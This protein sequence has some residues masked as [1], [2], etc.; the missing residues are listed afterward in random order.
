MNPLADATY[1]TLHWIAKRNLYAKLL[2]YPALLQDSQASA[3]FSAAQNGNIGKFH[4]IEIGI[5]NLYDPE[6][7]ADP[8]QKL[9]ELQ[10]LNAS[11]STE[12]DYQVHEKNIN[13][14]YL[15]A[16][17]QND[18]D[19][20]EPEKATI[21]GVAALCPQAA[22]N[23]VCTAR[24]LQENYRVP[25]WN[26]DCAFVGARDAGTMLNSTKFEIYPNPAEGIVN[27]AF[28]QPTAAG[29]RVELLS[30][31][32]QVLRTHEVG[33]GNTTLSLPVLLLPNG[34][35]FVRVSGGGNPS[36]LRKVSIIH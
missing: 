24:L 25:Y 26:M 28:S 19:F 13:T 32:G 27:L 7:T 10:S 18:W 35:Y 12:A 3:F 34:Y 9:A 22:G 8:A 36:A 6:L 16:L 5:A 2:A 23:A 4:T 11:I 1:A 20:S 17:S 14:V 29:C 33:E 31:T 15:A 30:T 21:D